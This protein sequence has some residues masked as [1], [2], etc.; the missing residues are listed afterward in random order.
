MKLVP[1]IQDVGLHMQHN[2]SYTHVC[3]HIHTHTVYIGSYQK[4]GGLYVVGVE[5]GM[6][7]F[8]QDCMRMRV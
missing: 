1:E 2:C 3:A 6:K 4:V 7:K 5:D 8:T